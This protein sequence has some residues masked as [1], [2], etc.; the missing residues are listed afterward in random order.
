MTIRATFGQCTTRR[1]LDGRPVSSFPPRADVSVSIVVP[2]FRSR[3]F[4]SRLL[5]SL[6]GAD[7]TPL[8]LIFVSD[9]DGYYDVPQKQVIIPARRGYAGAVNS[10]AREAAGR[11]IC[12][13]NAD[14]EVRQG[15]LAPMVRLLESSTDVGAVGNRNLDARGRMDSVGS[16]FSW[17]TGNF[18][19]CLRGRPDVPSPERDS[20]AERDAMTAACLLVRRNLWERLGGMD[21]AYRVAYF[22]DTDFCLRLRAAGYRILYCPDS[23]I[24][25]HKGHSGASGHRFYRANRDLFHRRWVET[26]LVDM[27]ARMRGR[28]VHG[29][30]VVA[31][32]I[33]LNEAE[34]IAPSIESVYPLA[35]RIVIVEGGNDYAVAAGL[36][37][38]DKRSSDGTLDAMRAVDDPER[39]I[40][41]V[42]GAW[43]DKAEQR[44]AYAARLRPGDWMLAMDGDEVFYEAGLWRLSALMHRCDVVMPGFDLFWNDFDTVGTGIWNEFQQVKAVRWAAGYHY[45]DHNCPCDAA[46]RPVTRLGR[47]IR[48]DERLYAH[49]SWVKPVAKLRA[50]AAYYERQPGARER[51]R[52]RYMEDV[53]L[54]WREKPEEISRRH[55]THPFGG[56]GAE[57][58]TGRHPGPIARRIEAGAFREWARVM[59]WN[60]DHSQQRR[61]R[62]EP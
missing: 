49:Y 46:G 8:E 12:L 29:G 60:A 31:C 6:S 30:D 15:W 23:A 26:G 24:V 22:E 17:A 7:P 32:Y 47:L 5:Q 25:H 45:R 61:E 57:R 54:A 21:E 1:Y 9:G 44:N 20:V 58:F 2:L 11:Y 14:V 13:L 55:G 42:S 56:G 3:R 37:G 34:F 10:G 39:K 53:F 59:Q 18:E 50:K 52:P 28:R 43:R 41:V 33:V 36:C 48:T 19:H 4:V 40:E 35:D 51:M 16:E 38:P 27:F 62:E